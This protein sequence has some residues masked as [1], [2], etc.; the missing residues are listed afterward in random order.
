MFE[1]N[2]GQSMF[3]Y[4]LY[5]FDREG[6][7][8]IQYHPFEAAGHEAA[9][10]HAGSLNGHQPMELWSEDA[11][12]KSWPHRSSGATCTCGCACAA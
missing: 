6:G 10:D 7:L 4:N 1:A 3:R 11:L 2:W 12:V 5:V 9:V 8:I